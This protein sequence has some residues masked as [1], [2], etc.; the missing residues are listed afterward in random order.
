M[1]LKLLL[2]YLLVCAVM[3]CSSPKTNYFLNK[4]GDDSFRL[5]SNTS[6]YYRGVD[7]EGAPI[8]FFNHLD[9]DCEA[10]LI[11]RFTQ[12]KSQKRLDFKLISEDCKIDTSNI[13]YLVDEFMKLGVNFLSVDSID[14]VKVGVDGSETPNLIRIDEQELLE[15]YHASNWKNIKD[16]WYFKP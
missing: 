10:P 3:A 7:M 15:A 8:I 2:V 4:H 11:V 6:I 13:F 1:K 16:R 14:I 5:F 9:D 12:D